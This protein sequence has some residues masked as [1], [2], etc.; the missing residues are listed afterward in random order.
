M[1]L[2]CQLDADWSCCV[3]PSLMLILELLRVSIHTSTCY[4]VAWC[5][6]V[7]CT[8][9][10][11]SF[12]FVACDSVARHMLVW[13]SP[14]TPSAV[15]KIE[16]VQCRAP[17]HITLNWYRRTSN[18][19][20]M[21]SKLYWQPLVERCRIAKLVIFFKK[22]HC[23]LVAIT[24]LLMPKSYISSTR[25][26]NV[27]AYAI[28]VSTCD[29]H[30]YSFY[31][32]RTV[33]ERNCPPQ[34]MVEAGTFEALRNAIRAIWIS[35]GNSTACCQQLNGSRTP[36]PR[37]RSSVLLFVTCTTFITNAQMFV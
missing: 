25:T 9:V 12:D 8:G 20:A 22:I 2:F 3:N 1:I 32:P 36:S 34:T 21:L 26:D 13:T 5:N 30:V 10:N 27:L 33:R 14:Y 15:K 31:D 23:Q 24:T 6:F 29:Y 35:S 19:G 18:A 37:S 16:L 28:P 4:K 17:P 11:G 7:A